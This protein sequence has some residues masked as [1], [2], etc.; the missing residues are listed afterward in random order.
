MNDT[1]SYTLEEWNNEKAAVLTVNTG[2]LGFYLLIGI[3]GNMMVIYIYN[4]RMKGPR[5]DRYFIPHL[6]VMDLCACVVGAGYAVALNLLPLRFQGNE[7]CKILWFLN[8][9]TTLCAALMLV[10]IAVQR[11]LK[12]VRPFKKQM[13][14]KA[15]HSALVAVI[16]LSLFLSLPCLMFYGEIP[17]HNPYL[18]LTGYR[19]GVS[20]SAD[21][22]ALSLYNAILFLTAVGGLLVISVLYILIGRTIYRQHKFRRRHSSATTAFKRSDR[23]SLEWNPPSDSGSVQTRR[24][25]VRDSLDFDSPFLDSMNSAPSSPVII[26]PS[27]SSPVIIEPSSPVSANSE[28]SSPFKSTFL[29]VSMTPTEKLRSSFSEIQKKAF[30]SAIPVRRHFGTHRCS[31]MFMMITVVY[32]LSFIPRITLN[33]LESTDKQFWWKFSDREIASYLFL[34]HLYLVNNISNPFFYGLFDRALRKELRKACC[35]K[36]K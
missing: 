17:I 16:L 32:V 30:K 10:V 7:L 14:I 20:P 23:D 29:S 8:Q 12:V 4:F 1:K 28:P 2:V 26:E 27:S 36:P 19:C 34:Y 6:A 25:P 11:Y 35:C 22:A 31:W 3:T 24:K 13:T 9:V 18:N 15:K 21:Q 5:D 33:V